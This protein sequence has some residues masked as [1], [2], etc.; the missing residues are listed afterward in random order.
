MILG[1]LKVGVTPLDMA[2][3]YETFATRRRQGVQ[4]AAR[5][6]R[7]RDPT[8]IA[9]I[10]CPGSVCR[11]TRARHRPPDLRA[12]APAPVVAK[13]VHDILTGVVSVGHRH[14]RRRS[15]ASTW[16]ARPEP[17]RTTATP[18]SSAGRRELTTAVWVGYPDKL[19]S[20]ATAYNGRPVEGGT[21]PAIIWHDFMVQALSDPAPARQPPGAHQTSGL[22]TT[23]T[24]TARADHPDRRRHGSAAPAATSAGARRGST[25]TGTGGGTA[26]GGGGAT[27]GGTAAG[28]ATGGTARR[29]RR[30]RR[31]HPASGGTRPAVRV[32]ARRRP[33]A[34]ATGGGGGAGRSP[35]AAA[36]A[37]GSPAA[38]IRADRAAA[39]PVSR[40]ATARAR[41]KPAPGG[42][43]AP[44]QLDRLGDPDPAVDRDRRPR[45][46]PPGDAE[47]TT[48]P[49][50]RSRRCASAR[51]PAPG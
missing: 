33:A 1:G 42:A 3:A 17:R 47:I 50:A 30:R 40:G 43:E 23:G 6:P 9:E 16:S 36:P 51:R 8:G 41:Q 13:T 7:R 48:G 38:A 49:R 29:R 34:A 39:A 26:A 32:A 20:M 21:Y 28:T 12:R 2:H 35:A 18:G 4:P 22:G 24:A 27:G 15:P 46:R 45:A 44:R 19:V 10:Q 11:G 14:R 37:A 25:G 5:R 31:R